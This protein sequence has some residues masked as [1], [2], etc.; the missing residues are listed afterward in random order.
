MT[1]LHIFVEWFLLILLTLKEERQGDTLKVSNWTKARTAESL[2][3]KAQICKK[4]VMYKPTHYL[5]PSLLSILLYRDKGQFTHLTLCNLQISFLYCIST[6]FVTIDPKVMTI[7]PKIM[8][9]D[10]KIMTIDPKILQKKL[11]WRLQ[12]QWAYL[13]ENR[14]YGHQGTIS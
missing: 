11:N 13:G 2:L 7:D 8:T 14:D 10:P 3:G 9:I 5:P 6:I 1:F 4:I 12:A